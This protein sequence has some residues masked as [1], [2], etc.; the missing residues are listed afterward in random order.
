MRIGLDEK[1]NKWPGGLSPKLVCT[2]GQSQ[3]HPASTGRGPW[4]FVVYWIE[5]NSMH[6]PPLISGYMMHDIRT[7]LLRRSRAG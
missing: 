1:G 4:S 7:V 3:F 6:D 2:G 5:V